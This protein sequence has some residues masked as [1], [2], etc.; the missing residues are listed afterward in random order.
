M[1]YFLQEYMNNSAVSFPLVPLQK[2]LQTAPCPQWQV[3]N[4]KTLKHETLTL[5]KSQQAGKRMERLPTQ[6]CN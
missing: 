2:Q 6:A 1:L 5:G 4:A 3:A